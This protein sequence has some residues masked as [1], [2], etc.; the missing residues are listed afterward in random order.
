MTANN[1]FFQVLDDD[2][3]CHKTSSSFGFTAELFFDHIFVGPGE[4]HLFRPAA[5]K[6]GL[7]SAFLAGL[8]VEGRVLL[9]DLGTFAV[10]ATNRG[11]VVF[12]HG[13]HQGEFLFAF[14]AAVF[15]DRHGHPLW[16]E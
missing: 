4:L 12:R 11:T 16:K 6:R 8:G 3:T 13:H 7:R 5:V 14:L 10:R 15:V 2:L 9:D 1:F